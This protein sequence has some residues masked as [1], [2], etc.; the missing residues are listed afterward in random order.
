M[1][2]RASTVMAGH[3]PGLPG[4]VPD[5]APVRPVLAKG[6]GQRAG[7][8]R[9]WPLFSGLGPVGALPTAPGLARAFAALVLVGWGLATVKDETILIVSE[10]TTNVVHA[11]QGEDGTPAY[12]GDGRLPAMWLR[13]MADRAELGVEVWD[14]LPAAA[15]TPALHHADPGAESGRGLEIVA[16]LSLA[17][18]WE[19]VPGRQAKRTWATLP[20]PRRAPAEDEK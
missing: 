6:R 8:G 20:I 18:G 13:L 16:S 7:T 3:A 15:G 17:W 1:N 14:T 11:A 9:F 19:P 2:G 12:N 10:L 4:G 5:A